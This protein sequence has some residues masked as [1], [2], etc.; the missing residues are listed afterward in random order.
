[1][2]TLSPLCIVSRGWLESPGACN[3]Q[4]NQWTHDDGS[5]LKWVKNL[6]EISTQPECNASD[7][8][9]KPHPKK[10]ANKK[11]VANFF[12]KNP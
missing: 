5:V 1:M 4:T 6:R 2:A 8:S 7:L 3:T 12:L 11:E 9:S 10:S